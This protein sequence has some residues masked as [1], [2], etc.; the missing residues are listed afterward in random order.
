MFNR[1]FIW[2]EGHDDL[3]FFEEIVKPLFTPHFDRIIVTMYAEMPDKLVCDFIKTNA[4]KN[5]DYI[6]QADI[7][8]STKSV[9]WK[10]QKI[11]ERYKK[12]RC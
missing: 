6:F 4:G 11:I 2:V 9:D 12:S 10:K 8:Y 7:D 1:L 5:R 3:R